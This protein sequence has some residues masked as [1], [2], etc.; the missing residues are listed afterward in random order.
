MKADGGS[1]ESLDIQVHEGG[2]EDKLQALGLKERARHGQGLD[3]LV[4]G[5][6]TDGLHLALPTHPQACADGAGYR[7]RTRLTRDLER[8]SVAIPDARTPMTSSDRKGGTRID[9]HHM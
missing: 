5:G 7:R 1:L 8:D 4:N 2:N 6:S 3:R 9:L